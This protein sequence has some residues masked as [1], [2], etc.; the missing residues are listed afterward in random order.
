MFT[1][2]LKWP[3]GLFTDR[4]TNPHWSALVLAEQVSSQLRVGD[5]QIPDASAL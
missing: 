2:N 1:I 5:R 3:A 4:Q